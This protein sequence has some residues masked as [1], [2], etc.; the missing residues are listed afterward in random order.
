MN[1]LGAAC[2]RPGM[3]FKRDD[4]FARSVEGFFGEYVS[5]FTSPNNQVRADL[6]KDGSGLVAHIS[7]AAGVTS[8]SATDTYLS[9]LQRYA[10]ELGFKSQLRLV[11]SGS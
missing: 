1:P 6:F 4:D 8:G 7:F 11:F 5:T 3:G 10:D 2:Y 9:E